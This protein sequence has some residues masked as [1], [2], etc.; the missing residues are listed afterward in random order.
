MSLKG[1]RPQPSLDIPQHNITFQRTQR[2]TE[3]QSLDET[4]YISDS[5]FCGP[6]TSRNAELLSSLS[7]YRQFLQPLYHLHYGFQEEGST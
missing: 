3:T 2:R 7:R 1:A 4:Q 6:V 5:H